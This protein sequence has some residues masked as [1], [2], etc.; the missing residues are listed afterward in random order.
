MKTIKIVLF[1]ILSVFLALA[2]VSVATASQAEKIMF[3]SFN[4]KDSIL[5]INDLANGKG[6]VPSF[7]ESAAL[8]RDINLEK[9]RLKIYS[10][11]KELLY[12]SYFYIQNKIF[13]DSIDEATG[14]LSGEVLDL[15]DINF[16]V[17]TPYFS[18]IGSI[19]VY[20]DY[21]D[22]VLDHADI[23]KLDMK[24]EI[25]IPK[26]PSTEK[27]EENGIEKEIEKE[28]RADNKNIETSDTNTFSS[29]NTEKQSF[30]LELI[31]IFGSVYHYIFG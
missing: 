20:S 17:I 28:Q 23:K 5:T 30:F 8:E 4:V 2:A 26:V 24:K 31:E 12:D 19:K 14:E 27:K 16:T 22:I 13:K 11:D 7:A 15:N 6:F 21:N 9:A 10:E 18:N 1:S 3:I 29:D 25:E